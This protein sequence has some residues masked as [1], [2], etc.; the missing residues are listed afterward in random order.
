MADSFWTGTADGSTGIFTVPFPY[1]SQTDVVVQCNGV[2]MLNPGDYTF[3]N[4]GAIQFATNP[5]QGTTVNIARQTS[6]DKKL[7]NFNNGA[8]LTAADLNTATLQTFYRTQEL[9][10]QL[11]AYIS[12]GIAKYSVTGANPFVTP[13]DLI[14]AAADAVLNTQLAQDLQQRITDIDQN[15]QD[16]IAQTTRTDTL[17]STLDSITSDIPGGIGTYLTNETDSRILGDQALAS[18][19]AIIGAT[20]GAGTAFVLNSGSVY[21]DS[22]TSLSDKLSQIASQFGSATAAITAESTTRATQDSALSTRIDSLTATVSGG[23]GTLNAAIGSEQ[24]ARAQADGALASNVSALQATVTSNY[25]T[26]SASITNEQT[27]RASGDQANAQAITSLSTTVNGN[28]ASI[29]TQQTAINGLSAEYT[30]KVDVNGHV[31]GF[32]LASTP[33]NGSTISDFIVLANRFSV[34]DPGNGSATPTIPFTVQNG[35]CYMQNVVIGGALIQDLSITSAKLANATITN[36]QIANATITNAQIANATVTGANIA[37]ATIMSANIGLA[38][39]T[40][41]LIA[42]AAIGSAQIGD[43]VVQSAHIA[44][45]AVGTSNVQD[46]AITA[47]AVVTCGSEPT[48]TAISFQFN[49]KGGVLVIQSI[50]DLFI[51]QGGGQPTLTAQLLVDGTVIDT[52]TAD[53]TDSNATSVRLALLGV[54]Q[55]A[56]GIHNITLN[57][58]GTWYGAVV[59]TE[60]KK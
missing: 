22:Q 53:V 9:Q 7:V 32:G 14:Q 33:V 51:L 16:I 27:V 42:N 26:L 48:G 8:I 40:T 5:P 39:I 49:S 19:L 35:V 31:A 56:A 28:T 41:A 54:S 44:N 29:Q 52:T 1:I 20:N 43:L 55:P 4:A 37:N 38:Q 2:T 18:T 11:D 15:A 58:S 57:S 30:V 17:Q 12:S 60:Y 59:V 36:A 13:D 34:I 3:L 10:D 25:T 6:P 47:T 50:A 21:V 45:L 23:Y 46:N 24:T